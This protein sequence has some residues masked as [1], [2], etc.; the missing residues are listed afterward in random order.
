MSPLKSDVLL[1]VFRCLYF[2]F[3]KLFLK[4]RPFILAADKMS[5]TEQSVS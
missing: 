1:F 5:A 3:N 4:Q 2:I